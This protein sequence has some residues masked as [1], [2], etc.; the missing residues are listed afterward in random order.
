MRPK[1][2]PEVV[3]KIIKKDASRESFNEDKLRSG[4]QT[5]LEKRPVSSDDVEKAIRHI[6]IQLRETGEREVTRHLVGKLAMNELKELDKV[7]YIRFASVYLSFDNINEFTK[8]IE[9]LKD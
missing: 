9:S 2:P 4:I 7:A 1:T 8:E 5:A 3:Q 6:I